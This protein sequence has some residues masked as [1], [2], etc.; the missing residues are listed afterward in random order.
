MKAIHRPWLWRV[1]AAAKKTAKKSTPAT[2]E[3]RSMA[4]VE[5]VPM[6]TPSHTK[7]ATPATGMA[8]AQGR[9]WAAAASTG[10]SSVRS[11]RK[12]LPP[13]A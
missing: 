4:R 11:D 7:A 10:A 9:Y 1:G 2:A 5:V 6:N 3:D 13:R 8:T 12:V